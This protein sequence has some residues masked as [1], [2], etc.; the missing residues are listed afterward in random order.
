MAGTTHDGLLTGSDGPGT[1]Y[2]VRETIPDLAVL[3]VPKEGTVTSTPVRIASSVKQGQPIMVFGYLDDRDYSPAQN[4]LIAFPGVVGATG[5]WASVDV[6]ALILNS[7]DRNNLKSAPI[8]DRD[9]S[10]VGIV[11]SDRDRD[12]ITYG[13]DFTGYQSFWGN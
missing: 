10:L 8:F 1:E 12:P 9:G 7:Q 5:R 3:L 4:F 2:L 6:L 13:F 11:E